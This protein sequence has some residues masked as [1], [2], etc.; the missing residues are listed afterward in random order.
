MEKFIISRFFFLAWGDGSEREDEG[1]ST[2]DL[3]ELIIVGI[4]GEAGLERREGLGLT[5]HRGL[6]ACDFKLVTLEDNNV[7]FT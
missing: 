6:Q 7:W 5:V 2:V 3:K 4:F 1:T